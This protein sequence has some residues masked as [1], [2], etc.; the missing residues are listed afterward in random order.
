MEAILNWANEREIPSKN[1]QA[2][3]SIDHT[4]GTHRFMPGEEDGLRDRFLDDL[5]SIRHT[6][7][8]TRRQTCDARAP[9]RAGLPIARRRRRANAFYEGT[10]IRIRELPIALGKPLAS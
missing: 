6:G 10:G 1:E 5:Y 7:A 3:S 8:V 4:F 2:N 9:R